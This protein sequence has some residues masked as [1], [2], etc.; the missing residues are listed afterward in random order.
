MDF[1]I[2]TPGALTDQSIFSFSC[3]FWETSGQNNRLAP[4][5]LGLHLPLRNAGSATLG[6]CS[7]ESFQKALYPF[8]SKD[9]SN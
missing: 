1:P 7:M 9:Q 6:L 2:N 8:W 3:S 5:P 4:P